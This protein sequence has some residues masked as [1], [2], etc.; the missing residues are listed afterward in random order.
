MNS[1]NPG[2]SEWLVSSLA[3]ECWF[4]DGQPKWQHLPTSNQAQI[5]RIKRSRL[6]KKHGDAPLGTLLAGCAR[7]ARCLSGC[8][9]EC[10]RALQRFFAAQC[11]KLLVPA[12]EY[13]AVSVVG[14]THRRLGRLHTLSLYKFQRYLRRALRRG[15]A[16]IAVG[17]I[18][19][20]FNEFPRTNQVSRWVPQF[21]LLIH[22][23]N[24]ARWENVLRKK[25]PARA[26]VPRPIKIQSWD[27]NIAAAGYALKTSFIRRRMIQTGRYVRGEWLLCRNTT[28]DRL[29]AAERVE[30][31]RYL[32]KVGLEARIVLL[33][34]SKVE[35][36]FDVLL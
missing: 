33:D 20:S 30:L 27:G 35:G 18:D 14:R 15:H 4:G 29:R 2:P 16:G 11:E 10:G 13:D 12:Q 6:L 25:Y 32:H 5:E 31:F 26:L 3:N 17:G 1:Q 8:C 21:W 7:G 24:R 28:H 36:G 19:F 23:A 9:P 34:V 22:N